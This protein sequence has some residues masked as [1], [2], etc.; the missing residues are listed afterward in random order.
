MSMS[1]VAANVMPA[2]SASP[3][4]EPSSASD[5]D[6][7]DSDMMSPAPSAPADVRHTAGYTLKNE[8]RLRTETTAPE[9]ATSLAWASLVTNAATSN[10]SL[11]APRSAVSRDANTLPVPQA[12]HPRAPASATVTG[13]Y[14]IAGRGHNRKAS[15]SM[16]SVVSGEFGAHMRE[17][18][19]RTTSVASGSVREL[20]RTPSSAA[21]QYY[22]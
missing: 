6:T 19:S 2:P 10:G 21:E 1:I 20:A 18:P 15:G 13:H 11:P 3:P 9:G 5:Y 14:G 22:F 16:A 8:L 12:L 4:A 7:S 17:G